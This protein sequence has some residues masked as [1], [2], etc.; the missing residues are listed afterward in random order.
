MKKKKQRRFGLGG[1]ISVTVL[2]ISAVA[3]LISYISIFI[4]PSKF[5]P[6]LFFGLYY[7]P[8]ALWNLFLLIIAIIRMKKRLL[9][10]LVALLPSLFFFDM[11]VKV[12]NEVPDEEREGICIVTYNVGRYSLSK[13]GKSKKET[14]V[15]IRDYLEL[16]K[17]DII[18]LQEVKVQ[19][20]DSLI[21]IPDYPYIHSHFFDGTGS[22]FGNVILSKF[23]IRGGGKLTFK[24]ST[25]LAIWA[26]L[27]IDRGIVRIYNCHLE[28]YSISFTS[29]VK[30]LF[31]KDT[32]SDE[33]IS[34]HGHLKESNIKRAEQV[35]HVV[36]SISECSL[37]TIVCGDFNDTPMSYTYHQLQ[38]DHKDCFVEAGKGFGATY[39]KLWPALRLDY[40]LIPEEYRTTY[41]KIERVPFSDHYPVLTQI[42][43][44]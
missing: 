39:S 30:R 19:Y 4:S 11:F 7:I 33:F 41:H 23:P 17:A 1:F 36:N 15:E 25:N 35:D 38:K 29:I 6:P 22:S 3:L 16:F 44:D 42:I 32:F 5:W 2:L 28:S 34:L 18:C 43:L 14:I 37:K 40:I 8:I 10:P 9:I 27:L 24:N 21:E 26:D 31:N 13:N 12:G 20:K